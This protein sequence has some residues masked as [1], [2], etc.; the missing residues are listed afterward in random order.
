MITRQT[1]VGNRG[2]TKMG[3][4]DRVEN[5]VDVR[6][7][8]RVQT[9]MVKKRSSSINKQKSKTK[10]RSP[11]DSRPTI[12]VSKAQSGEMSGKASSRPRME[13]EEVGDGLEEQSDSNYRSATQ[14]SQAE[15]EAA[16]KINSQ[17]KSGR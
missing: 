4:R 3:S 9:K 6:R 7:K 17:L 13:G 16:S 1:R 15:A 2:M 5:P 12:K 11:K 8:S 14:K 10:V